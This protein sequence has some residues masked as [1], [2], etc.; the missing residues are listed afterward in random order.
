VLIND[1]GCPV[2]LVELSASDIERELANSDRLAIDGDARGDPL[3]AA[4]LAEQL[5]HQVTDNS[6]RNLQRHSQRARQLERAMVERLL[7]GRDSR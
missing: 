2:E 7:E 5:G 4:L 1:P 3:V 6:V